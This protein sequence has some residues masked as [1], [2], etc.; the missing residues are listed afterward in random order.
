[1]PNWCYQ[2]LTV[3]GKSKDEIDKFV[4][5][6]TANQKNNE[7]SLN[8][9]YPTPEELANTDSAS[10]GTQE[11]QDA[12]NKKYEENLAKHGFKDWYEWNNANWGTKWGAC[13]VDFYGSVDKTNYGFMTQLS[14]NSAWSPAVGLIR[15]I[16]RLFPKLIFSLSYTEESDAFAGVEVFVQGFCEGEFSIEPDFEALSELD[17]DSEEYEMLYEKIRDEV[18]NKIYDEGV[19]L[20]ESAQ[21]AVP[22]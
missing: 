9:L 10:G 5:A 15:E 16:S 3:H 4:G 12:R 2:N 13:D 1:M 8:Q 6:I 11:Q 18:E 14:F 21:K 19:L 20:L 7:A 17:F 22:S